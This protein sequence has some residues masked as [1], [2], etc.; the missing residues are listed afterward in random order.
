MQIF[1]ITENKNRGNRS[2][3]YLDVVLWQD[4]SWKLMLA[5]GAI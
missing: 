3:F 1:H 2:T 5:Y 4:A